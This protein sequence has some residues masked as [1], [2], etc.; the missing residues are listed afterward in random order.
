MGRKLRGQRRFPLVLTL[1]P[2]GAC[3]DSFV[4]PASSR[5]ESDPACRQDGGATKEQ[6]SVL[7]AA[8]CLA[9]VEECGALVVVISG[10]EPLEYPEIAALSRGILKLG[11]H[12]FLCT[13]GSLIRRNLHVISPDTKFFWNVKLDGTAGV[14]EK[15]TGRTGLF[16]AVL[17]GIRSAKNAGFLVVVTS[18]I[19]PDTDIGDL[20]SLYERLHALHV[21]GYLLSPHYS[22][23][24]LSR[25]GSAKFRKQMHERFG[26]VIERLGAYSPMLSPMY[27]EYL[28]GERELDCSMWTNPMFGPRGW[29][30]PCHLQKGHFMQSYKELLQETAW[31]N[32]G[33]GS[34]PQCENCLYPQAFETAA[35]LGVNAKSGD[36][37]KKLAWQF[38]SGFGEKREAARRA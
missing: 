25:D 20:Q 35:I 1:D 10:G 23:E 24:K 27:L 29:A 15:R 8:N 2:L 30:L 14:H 5:P 38:R 16:A 7:T 22:L 6:R 19:Y 37:W 26:E 17:D 31:E 4:A 34:N 9:A 18:T 32:D 12:L 33:R 28:R 11:K 3:S 36:L 21:D 13:H